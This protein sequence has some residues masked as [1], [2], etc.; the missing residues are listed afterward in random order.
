MSI[1]A[2]AELHTAGGGGGGGGGMLFP[3]S[4]ESPLFKPI[5]VLNVIWSKT[6]ASTW[7][8]I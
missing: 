6:A 4:G 1:A 8:C 5:L 3:E 2:D 7:P